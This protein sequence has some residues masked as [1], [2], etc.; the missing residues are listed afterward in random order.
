MAEIRLETIKNPKSPIAEAYRTLRTNIQFSSY[1]KKVRVILVTSSIPS[2]GKTTTASNLAVTMAQA[3]SR[4]IL[5]DCD[6]RNPKVHKVFGLSNEKGLSNTLIDETESNDAILK[7]DVN[8][9]YVLTSGTRI[10]NPSELL[11]ADIMQ[12]FINDLKQSY[13]YIIIDTPPILL[14][15]DAQIAAKY[16]DGCIL[17]VASAETD[18]NAALKSKELLKKV[19]ARI[20]GVVLNK[21]D[22]RGKQS[23]GYHYQYYY[24]KDEK[25]QVG[26]K[27]KWLGKK[28]SISG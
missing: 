17:V 16:S 2:E 24:G 12:K 18:K 13:D 10:P 4:T 27:K 20:L 22:T 15:T 6:M 11:S 3:G 21:L 14:V 7:T 25:K 23:Y 26:K 5:I 8:N 1:G 9:L 19:D 28:G